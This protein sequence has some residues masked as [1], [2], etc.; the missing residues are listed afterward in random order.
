M[1]RREFL[2]VGVGA[3]LDRGEEAGEIV[4]VEGDGGERLFASLC[5]TFQMRPKVVVA[6]GADGGVGRGPW[7]GPRVSLWMTAWL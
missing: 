5:C 7:T 6:V 3:G 4:A 2:H 1:R